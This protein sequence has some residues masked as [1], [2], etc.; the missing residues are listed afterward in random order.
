MG[1]R[2][3]ELS[4]HELEKLTE[5]VRGGYTYKQISEALKVR[6]Q[7]S[8][9]HY[10]WGCTYC[11]RPSIQISTS[12]QARIRQANGIHSYDREEDHDLMR[13]IVAVAYELGGPS[14]GIRSV[15]ARARAMTPDLGYGECPEGG[16]RLSLETVSRLLKEILPEEYANRQFGMQA[17]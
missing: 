12:V 15:Q 16:W 14:D 13:A 9:H 6:A 3:I 5:M 4:W 8:A 10:Y 1:R 7:A 17:R 2:P 11:Y